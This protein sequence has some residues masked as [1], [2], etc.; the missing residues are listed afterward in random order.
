M[1]GITHTSSG[2][3]MIRTPKLLKVG[4]GYPRGKAC[5]VF[6]NPDGKWV[7]RYGKKGGD[8]KLAFQTLKPLDTRALAEATFRETWKIADIC[9][10]PRKVAHFQFSR[11]VMGSDGAEIY[12]PCFDAIEAYSFANPDRPGPPTEIDVMFLDDEPFSGG[13]QMW[14]AS[15]L[16][17]HGDGE[18]AL[19]V[20]AMAETPQDKELAKIAKDA[21]KKYFPIIDGCWTKGCQFA[22]EGVDKRGNPTPS[23]CKPSADIRFQLMKYLRATETAFFHTGGYKTIQQLFSGI[24]RIKELTQGR[25]AMVRVN[26]VI[27]SHKTNHNGQAAIQQNI[28]IQ[29]RDEDRDV[30]MSLIDKAWKREMATSIAGPARALTAVVEPVMDLDDLESE[31]PMT[32]S[33]MAAEFYPDT[34]EAI[35]EPEPEK[36]AAPSRTKEQ[37]AADQLKAR[38][39]TKVVFPWDDA[40]GMRTMIRTEIHRVGI[41]ASEP[42]VKKYSMELDQIEPMTGMALSL[43]NDLKKL[44]AAASP[45]VTPAQAALMED[46]F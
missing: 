5:E 28:S 19:R 8:G 33:A 40:D 20:L 18:N 3:K 34:D 41:Q 23:P 44:P 12:V 9:P 22:C 17:C 30:W 45:S 36:A 43:Y 16:K 15:E 2:L 14:S 4:I 27:R 26:L 13:Y 35:P 10:Y 6:V 1:I 39:E 42:V 24:E 7:I 46:P 25:M 37:I 11:P 31:S 38:K 21:G 29:P 32:A